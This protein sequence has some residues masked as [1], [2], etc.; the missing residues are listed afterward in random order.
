[1]WKTIQKPRRIYTPA[2]GGK[3]KFV[4]WLLT[5]KAGT[6]L[7]NCPLGLSKLYSRAGQKQLKAA[8]DW[9]SDITPSSVGGMRW[10]SLSR[11]LLTWSTFF[12]TSL[13]SRRGSTEHWIIFVLLCPPHWEH[14]QPL[15]D[16]WDKTPCYADLW[17]ELRPPII[18]LFPSWEVSSVL[19][20]L[21]LWGQAKH[22]PLKKLL[23]KTAFL[24]ALVCFK[25]PADLCNMQVVDGYW[26]LNMR[27]FT[28]QPLGFGK[29]ETHNP[30]PPLVIEPYLEDPQSII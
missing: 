29:T 6:K 21:K 19:N 13:I 9:V 24:V 11:V 30:T 2:S 26:I 27:G 1:M 25:R 7:E 20:C 14:V 28:C 4:V 8:M 18:K 17:E 10:T 22:L 15:A 23:L 12:S 5:E 16:L 3:I